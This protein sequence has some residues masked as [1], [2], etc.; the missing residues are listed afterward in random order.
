M[1]DRD[2]ITI[3]GLRIVSSIG[4]TDEEWA[5]PQSLEVSLDLVPAAGLRG[6]EDRLERTVDYHAVS[7]LVRDTAAAG[8]RRLV[9]T[10]AEDLGSAVLAAFPTLA[11]ARVTVRK[12][13]LADAESVAVALTAVRGGDG[14]PE[15]GGGDGDAGR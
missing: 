14:L 13:I 7:E 15:A 9:E 2:Q 4:V 10:L 5:R 12:F 11:Q 8:R 3:S 6:L 1:T